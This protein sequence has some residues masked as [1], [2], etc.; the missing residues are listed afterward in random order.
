[1]TVRSGQLEFE[2]QSECAV[3]GRSSKGILAGGIGRDDR[4][5]RP[6]DD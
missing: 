1:V 2:I 6:M 4:V 3:A 5:I